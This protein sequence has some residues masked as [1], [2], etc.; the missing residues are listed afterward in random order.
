[1]EYNVKSLHHRCYVICLHENL[2]TISVY[3]LFYINHSFLYFNWA[4]YVIVWS[5]LLCVEWDVKL[6]SPTHIYKKNY[7]LC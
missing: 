3:Y 5:D 1:M 2:R 4:G 7:N 6:Y